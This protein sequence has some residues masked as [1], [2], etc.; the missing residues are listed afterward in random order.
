ME[1]ATSR[2]RDRYILK[3][4]AYNLPERA[5]RWHSGTPRFSSRRGPG[6]VFRR[7]LRMTLKAISKTKAAANYSP[8]GNSGKWSTP[9]VSCLQA[10]LNLRGLTSSTGLDVIL[11][12]VGCLL[13]GSGLRLLECVRLRVC[14][15]DFE[16]RQ[17]IVRSG[18]G[19]KDCVVPMQERL[20]ALLQEQVENVRRLH[21]ENLA[22]GYGAVH[23]PCALARK[24]PSAA[25]V[26][27]RFGRLPLSRKTQSTG[28]WP[29]PRPP[30][31]PRW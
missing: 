25:R 30:A 4:I 13:Y 7:S 31:R 10:W 21:T 26:H 18:K 23:L 16:Y 15:L 11:L 8:T 17:I 3:T 12:R 6:D 28:N 20:M 27:W 14:D 5:R 22:A 9:C 29:R 19:D 2:F 24:F 1:D